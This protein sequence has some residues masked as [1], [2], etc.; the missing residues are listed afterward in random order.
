MFAKG[1]SESMLLN[2]KLRT[3]KFLNY[4]NT[5]EISLIILFL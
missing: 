4:P 1:S 2:A 3:T 5:E